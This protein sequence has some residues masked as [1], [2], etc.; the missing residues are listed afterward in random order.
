MT[1]SGSGQNTPEPEDGLF[2]ER[3]QTLYEKSLSDLRTFVQREGRSFD[4]VRELVDEMHCKHL[5]GL[6]NDDVPISSGN[7][8]HYIQNI[9]ARISKLFE[10]LERVAGLQSF[11]LV[12]NPYNSSDQGF[13]GGT[14][15]GRDFWQ[16]HRNCGAAGAQAFQL[17]TSYAPAPASSSSGGTGE[18]SN[19]TAGPFYPPTNVEVAGNVNAAMKKTP[20]MNVKSEVYSS[21]RAAIRAASGVRNAEMKW[22]NHSNLD[23]YNIRIVGWPED[24]PKANPSALNTAQNRRILDGLASGAI[25]FE[26][27]QSSQNMTTSSEVPPPE[28]TGLAQ[29]D[30]LDVFE[31]TIDFSGGGDQNEVGRQLPDSQAN[32]ITAG[33]NLTFIPV[34]PQGESSRKRRREE[35]DINDT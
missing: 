18:T 21:M 15:K 1:P 8:H 9:M 26:S 25:F 35:S 16:G 34:D 29:G 6:T 32:R 4:H 22:T 24:I 2:L 19:A 30:D 11:F 7:N 31:G 5:F 17:F 10:S 28:T 12:V 3:L 27:I 20:A 23:A 13:L 14:V 33:P